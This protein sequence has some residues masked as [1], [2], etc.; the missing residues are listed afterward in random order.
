MVADARR[1]IESTPRPAGSPEARL[2]DEIW[3]ALGGSKPPAAPE[4]MVGEPPGT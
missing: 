4:R 2:A 3:M 1:I